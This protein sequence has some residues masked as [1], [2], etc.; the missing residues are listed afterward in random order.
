MQTMWILVA[1]SARGR[2]FST[3][4]ERTLEEVAD[5]AHPESRQHDRDLVSD[6]QG[7]SFDSAGQG[8]HA[9]E[10]ARHPHEQEAEAFAQALA[11]AIEEGRNQH[12]F[13]RLVLIAPPEFLGRLRQHLH[14]DAARMVVAEIHKDLVHLDQAQLLSYL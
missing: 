6:Q 14:K 9:M 5:F 1:D 4:D 12:R 2:I 10:P 11:R 3:A 7:R 13:E 8:R